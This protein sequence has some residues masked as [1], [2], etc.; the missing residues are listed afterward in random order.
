MGLATATH[1]TVRSL[2]RYGEDVLTA[3]LANRAD[4][5][6]TASLL[7][8]HVLSY[9]AYSDLVLH[10]DKPVNGIFIRRYRSF[11]KRR[12][13]G[14]PVQY[15]VGSVAFMDLVLNVSPACLIPRPETELL[16]EHVLSFA[17]TVGRP[18]SVL[19]IGTGSGNIA[20]ALAFYLKDSMI[21]AVDVSKKA[22]S[23]AQHNAAHNHIVGSISFHHGVLFDAIPGKKRYTVIV[24]NPPYVS[25]DELLAAQPELRWEPR[26][27]LIAK[28]DGLEFIEKIIA[29]AYSRLEEHGALFLEIGYRHGTTVRSLLENNGYK[30]IAIIKDLSNHDRIACGYKK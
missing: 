19:D 17:R 21:D 15:I 11:L 3:T 30:Q 20:I 9:S 4:A 16:V 2:Q 14:E 12:K 5:S 10:A 26:K 7:L 27:A 23:L 6:Q 8:M 18:C 24:S 22:L 29:G 1:Y 25:R 28:N 13:R